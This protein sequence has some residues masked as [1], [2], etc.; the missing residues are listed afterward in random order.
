[1]ISKFLKKREKSL[2]LCCEKKCWNINSCAY[3]AKK[4]KLSWVP[5]LSSRLWELHWTT[6]NWKNRILQLKI[7]I[8]YP[9]SPKINTWLIYL[10]MFCRNLCLHQRSYLTQL[11]L[12]TAHRPQT[13]WNQKTWL[14]FLTHP[15][16]LTTDQSDSVQELIIHSEKFHPISLFKTC[17]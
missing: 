8:S 2:F 13:E 3:L 12:I 14:P 17:L 7:I 6:K 10:E 11:L 5:Q 9:S 1:M 16:L 15:C 4:Q